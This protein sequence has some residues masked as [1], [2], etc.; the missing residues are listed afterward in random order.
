MSEHSSE[1]AAISTA[2]SLGVKTIKTAS[3]ARGFLP[4]DNHP[5]NVRGKHQE[6]NQRGAFTH[7]F[8][9]GLSRTQRHSLNASAAVVLY[10]ENISPL[11]SSIPCIAR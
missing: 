5:V 3:S 1:Y 8:D 6:H 10:V 4:L 9:F 7:S 2:F 11:N